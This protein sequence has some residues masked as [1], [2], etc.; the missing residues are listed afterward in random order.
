MVEDRWVR[1]EARHRQL[2]DVALERSRG[3]QVARDVV[4]PEALAEVVQC[5]GRFHRDNSGEY[6]R[7]AGPGREPER[8][9]VSVSVRS[10]RNAD[11]D[12][13]ASVQR[14]RQLPL[15]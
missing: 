10:A 6:G 8:W 3:Q 4:E 15:V 12:S 13:I 1:G 14:Q 11:S 9:D 7:D 5:R 2:V